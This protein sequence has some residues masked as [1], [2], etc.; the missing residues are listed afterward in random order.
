[1]DAEID[2]HNWPAT[3]SRRPPIE[4][5]HASTDDEIDLGWLWGALAR[6]WRL[7]IAVVVLG[8]G[9]TAAPVLL[10]PPLYEATATLLVPGPAASASSNA[11]AVRNVFTSSSVL[12]KVTKALEAEQL[13]ASLSAGS[14]LADPVAGTPLVRLRVQTHDPAAAS[15]AAALL[16]EHGA[17]AAREM[18]AKALETARPLLDTDVDAA[19]KHLEAAEQR[20]LEFRRQARIE[21]LES[22]I[23]GQL[24]ARR[25]VDAID[26]DLLR[27]R[28]RLQAATGE[29]KELQRPAPARQ[30]QQAALMTA[31]ARIAAE[32]RIAISAL[33]TAKKQAGGDD[34]VT[35]SLDELYRRQTELKRMER[36]LEVAEQAYA[37]QL[38]RS[39]QSDAMAAVPLIESAESTIGPATSI[40]R[41]VSRKLALG[42]VLSLLVGVALVVFREAARS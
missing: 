35:K 17:V 38:A 8:T 41:D 22:E 19:A 20:F 6:R 26:G 31:V 15:R 5:R 13:H 39:H 32:S 40:G 37:A 14:V 25:A 10:S 42:G 33:E 16:T 2:Q 34:G 3:A 7:L 28:A 4:R 1:V 12:D 9:L 21:V 27:E 23:Q 24:A 36:Q 11:N 18:R 29:M 30:D